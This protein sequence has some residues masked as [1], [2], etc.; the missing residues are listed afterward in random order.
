ML[1]PAVL[2]VTWKYCI[3]TFSSPAL[4]LEAWVVLPPAER[5]S[6]LTLTVF[7]W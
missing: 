7:D 4:A 5:V 3:T 1:L 2:L 6:T